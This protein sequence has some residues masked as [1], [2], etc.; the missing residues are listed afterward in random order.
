MLV[1]IQLC[2]SFW[3]EGQKEYI[4]SVGQRVAAQL[5]GWNLE[6]SQTRFLLCQVFKKDLLGHKPSCNPKFKNAPIVYTSFLDVDH[7]AQ[8][9]MTERLTLRV[10]IKANVDP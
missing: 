1:T 8:K 6:Q 10:A 7:L 3:I 2:T 9:I 5:E 4:H